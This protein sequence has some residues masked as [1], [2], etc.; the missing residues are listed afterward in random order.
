MVSWSDKSPIS[1]RDRPSRSVEAPIFNAERFMHIYMSC[2]II[3]HLIWSYLLL[4]LLIKYGITCNAN[5][6]LVILTFI[7]I[8]AQFNLMY[9]NINDPPCKVLFYL[10]PSHGF[11]F[12]G[13]VYGINFTAVWQAGK[14]GWHWVPRNYSK[15]RYV[16]AETVYLHCFKYILENKYPKYKRKVHATKN[17]L[18]EPSEVLKSC[19]TF[20]FVIRI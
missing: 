14:F 10:S 1:R 6:I 11:I 2:C 5:L 9:V 20:S 8:L 13:F 19:K 3:L 4:R 17:S 16:I 7:F 15:F 12:Y 18:S